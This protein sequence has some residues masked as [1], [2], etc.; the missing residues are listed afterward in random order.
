MMNVFGD[1]GLYEMPHHN[2][3]FKPINY[4]K[5]KTMKNFKADNEELDED[6]VTA[7]CELI[8]TLIDPFFMFIVILRQNQTIFHHLNEIK[9]K[10]RIIE[11]GDGYKPKPKQAKKVNALV[12]SFNNLIAGKIIKFI[13]KFSENHFIAIDNMTP[14]QEY[15]KLPERQIDCDGQQLKLL[16]MAREYHNKEVI[17]IYTYLYTYYIILYIYFCIY[18]YIACT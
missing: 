6:I 7:G 14:E 18:L 8:S 17:Y 4:T 1:G 13:T 5:N 15:P 11:D 16:F 3:F 10:I 2:L 9:S 12:G